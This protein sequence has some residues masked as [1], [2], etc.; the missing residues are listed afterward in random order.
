[1]VKEIGLIAGLLGLRAHTIFPRVYS[2]AGFG[3]KYDNWE[4]RTENCF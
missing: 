2:S 4:L 1:M 3:R